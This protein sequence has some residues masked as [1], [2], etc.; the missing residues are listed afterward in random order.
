MDIIRRKPLAW[1]GDS[2]D[3]IRGFPEVAKQRT[4]RELA[5]VQEGLEPTDCKPMASI[6]LGVS[7][8]RVREDSGAFRVIYVAKFEEAIYVLHAFQKKARKT[9]KAEIELARK[10]YRAMLDERKLRWAKS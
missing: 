8:I 6:G 5:R 1:I 9:P 2:R 7:E 4:G 3:A 10:R